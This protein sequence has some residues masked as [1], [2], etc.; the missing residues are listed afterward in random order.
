MQGEEQQQ[1]QEDAEGASAGG[2]QLV[3]RVWGLNQIT[4]DIKGK[5]KIIAYLNEHQI[6]YKEE[7]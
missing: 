1:T 2:E 5:Q 6:E 7:V 3:H 4:D